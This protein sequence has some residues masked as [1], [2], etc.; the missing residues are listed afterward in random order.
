ML[1]HDDET[2]RETGRDSRGGEEGEGGGKEDVEEEEAIVARKPLAHRG[3][4]D[5]LVEEGGRG[6]ALNG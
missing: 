4:N 5:V 1:T 6:A 3:R 2:I